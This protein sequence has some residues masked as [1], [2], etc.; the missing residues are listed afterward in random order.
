LIDGSFYAVDSTWN[1]SIG[2]NEYL[3]VGK[4]TVCHGTAFGESHTPDMLMLEG[5]HKKF[6]FPD[7]ARLAYGI[8]ENK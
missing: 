7:I 4:E 6:V 8:T 5:P 2:K 1:D 3:L